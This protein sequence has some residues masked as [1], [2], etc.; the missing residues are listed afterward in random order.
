MVVLCVF[1]STFLRLCHGVFHWEEAPH[2]V[3][4]II[5][6]MHNALQEPVVIILAEKLFLQSSINHLQFLLSQLSPLGGVQRRAVCSYQEDLQVNILLHTLC[7]VGIDI[8]HPVLDLS[9]WRT[10]Q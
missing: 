8:V 4:F 5:D 10:L 3:S 2:W 1:S 7:V 9:Q 6:L